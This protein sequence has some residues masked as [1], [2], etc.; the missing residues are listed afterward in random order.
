[1]ST[2]GVA[3]LL[4]KKEDEKEFVV[5]STEDLNMDYH[6]LR[7]LYSF[8]EEHNG[9]MDIPK[10]ELP[11]IYDQTKRTVGCT[12]RQ[13]LKYREEQLKVL[14]SIMLRTDYDF[15]RIHIYEFDC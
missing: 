3:L 13:L 12:K 9:Y 10:E 11:T 15:I 6:E 1:M 8:R 14:D 2:Y 7:N 4:I 5:C